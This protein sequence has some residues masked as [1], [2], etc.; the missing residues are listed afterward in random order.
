MRATHT[1]IYI[2]YTYIYMYVCQQGIAS[3]HATLES[4]VVYNMGITGELKQ[5]FNSV[6]KNQ[7]GMGSS[8]HPLVHKPLRIGAMSSPQMSQMSQHGE[9]VGMEQTTSLAL[10]QKWTNTLLL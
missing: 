8:V 6:G 7:M 3:F 2:Q 9:V 1:H 10:A 4:T 5:I